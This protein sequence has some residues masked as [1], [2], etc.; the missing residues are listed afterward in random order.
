[1]NKVYVDKRRQ[2]RLDTRSITLRNKELVKK[3]DA[4]CLLT[5]TKITKYVE[6]AIKTKLLF[7]I[8]NIQVQIKQENDL[9][10]EK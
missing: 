9:K 10:G 4:Y 6:E 2:D 5:D 3:L 7:D 1:M 8:D